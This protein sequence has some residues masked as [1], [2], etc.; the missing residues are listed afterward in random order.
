MMLEKHSYQVG[1]WKAKQ[2]G[3]HQYRAGLRRDLPNCPKVSSPNDGAKWI[4]RITKD[5]YPDATQIIDWFHAAGK[6]W[7]IGK[8]TVGDKKERDLWA[9]ACL[10]DLWIRAFFCCSIGDSK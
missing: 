3:K 1:F 6:I 2:M 9:K 4:K 5:N 10:D 7:L 8:L